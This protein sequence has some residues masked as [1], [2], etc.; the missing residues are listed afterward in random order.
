M[1]IF[2]FFLSSVEASFCSG[3]SNINLSDSVIPTTNSLGCS[4]ALSSA[5]SRSIFIA[6]GIIPGKRAT[7]QL[8]SA[9]QHYQV[10][11][12]IEVQ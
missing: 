5:D 10:N 9:V 6:L 3:L 1:P 11:P 2:V 8:I 7:A 4:G 12:L